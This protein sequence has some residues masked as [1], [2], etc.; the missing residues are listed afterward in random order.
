M[1]F[2]NTKDP[3]TPP[4]S[5]VNGKVE[6][7]RIAINQDKDSITE[8]IYKGKKI[9]INNPNDYY[10]GKEEYEV[11]YQ[12]RLLFHNKCAYCERVEYKPDVEHYR[13]K[14]KVT[15]NQGNKHGYYWL[16]YEW[17]NLLP[18]CGACNSGNGKWNKF[19][20]AGAR[21]TNP[22]LN[23]NRLDFEKCKASDD[24][25]QNELP[26]LLHPEVDEPTHFL[27]LEWNGRLI[28]LDGTNGK[29]QASIITYD[30]NRGN[31]IAAR[32][33]IVD[34]FIEGIN[35]A[36]LLFRNNRLDVI[37]LQESLVNFL[38]NFKS[39]DIVTTPYSFVYFYICQNFTSFANDN[40]THFSAIEKQVLITSFP[41]VT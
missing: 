24:Y 27:K 11:R 14:K 38:T 30:L 34:D 10:H 22:P 2:I 9:V 20:V 13:P 25:L 31:L 7:E 17:T 18:A 28:G 33:R 8:A 23:A 35:E 19:P 26:L 15:G 3:N 6:Q 32:K 21:V 39:R 5:L 16:C 12:L 41:I 4:T 40:F 29:G 37:G 1:R 36:F